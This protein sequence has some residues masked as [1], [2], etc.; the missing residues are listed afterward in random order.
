MAEGNAYTNLLKLMSDKGYNKDVTI[1]VGRVVKL[2]PMEIE[3]QGYTL[4]E[5]DYLMTLS[6]QKA[7]EEGELKVKDRV[8]MIRDGN[9]FYAI[10]K[11][12]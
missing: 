7:N 2:S 8:L 12:V 10:D 11:V 5:D 1:S 9:D 4:E 6:F 3:L